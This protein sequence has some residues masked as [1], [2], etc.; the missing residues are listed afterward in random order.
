M[1]AASVTDHNA[2]TGSWKRKFKGTE[3]VLGFLATMKHAV[4]TRKGRA[5][6]SR[7]RERRPE[8]VLEMVG[9]GC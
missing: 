2:E 9:G 7:T 8:A 5:R 6:R 3:G 4:N 1:L